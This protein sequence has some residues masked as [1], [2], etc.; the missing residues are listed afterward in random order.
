MESAE[1]RFNVGLRLYHGWHK[2][3]QRTERLRA[4]MQTATPEFT[5]NYS[6]SDVIFGAVHYGHTLL[7]ALPGRFHEHQALHLPNTLRQQSKNEPRQEKMVDTALAADLLHWARYNPDEWALVVAEDDDFVPPL[8][9]AE[10]WIEGQGGR[11]LMVRSRRPDAYLK[12]DGLL[13]R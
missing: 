3:W 4:M 6:D 2:G 8:F 13:A 11:A 10:A 1:L 12:L 5:K 7:S 9:A